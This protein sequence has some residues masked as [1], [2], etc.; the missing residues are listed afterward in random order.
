VS[1]LRSPPRSPLFPYTTLFRSAQQL[2]LL[3]GA[4]LADLVEEDRAA[5]GL[6]EVAPAIRHRAREGALD[7]AEE[8]ALEELRG[9]G[10]HVHRDEGPGC[11]RAQPVGCPGEQLLARARL[12]GDQDGEGR[13]R[14]ALQVMKDREHGGIAGEDARLL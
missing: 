13:A 6:L 7:V 11:A 3:V 12:A 10:G 8:L 4:Q 2:A 9:N 1:S 14:R 5:V